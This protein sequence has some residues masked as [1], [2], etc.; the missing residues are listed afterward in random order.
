MN[1]KYGISCLPSY[2]NVP[3]MA[4]FSERQVEVEVC[5]WENGSLDINIQE[6]GTS[7]FGCHLDRKRAELFYI[8]IKNLCD[9]LQLAMNEPTGGVDE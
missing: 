7:A 9:K 6:N 4:R 2:I 3:T 5:R 8:N 1:G